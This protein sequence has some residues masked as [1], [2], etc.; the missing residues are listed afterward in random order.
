ML[1]MSIDEESHAEKK[2]KARKSMDMEFHDHL[3]T[4]TEPLTEHADGSSSR[5]PLP[6][7]SDDDSDFEDSFCAASD[8][9]EP[10]HT[11]L[12]E[13]LEDEHP[14]RLNLLETDVPPPRNSNHNTKP[15]SAPEE[16]PVA[17]SSDD[18]SS[19][20]ELQG[21][22]WDSDNEE[23]AARPSSVKVK[24]AS[25]NALDQS[26]VGP[27]DDS[28]GAGEE[29]DTFTSSPTT[30]TRTGLRDGLQNLGKSTKKSFRGVSGGFFAKPFK[31]LGRAIRRPGK[32]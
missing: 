21:A 13:I 9:C 4:D 1:I 5:Q 27:E 7:D 3:G 2:S 28:E 11:F 23:E 15:E 25:S 30:R 29:G 32:K 12:A 18:E 20:E 10:D 26:K 17:E 24:P 31:G 22:E 8:D 19:V 6:Y 16:K 14:E